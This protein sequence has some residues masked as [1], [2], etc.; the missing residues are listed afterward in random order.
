ML[1]PP[2]RRGHRAASPCS[3][4]A[5]GRVKADPGQI[6][7]VIMNLAVNARDA[8]PRRRPADDRDRRRRPRRRVRRGHPGAAPGRT[9][10]GRDRHRHRHGR[11]D[12]GPHLR[13]VLH[14]QGAGQGHRPGLST[15]YGIVEAERRLR[16]ASTASRAGHDVSTSTCRASSAPAAAAASR[17]A[18]AGAPG[19]RH[20][21]ILLVEDEAAVRELAR[22]DPRDDGLH[23]AARPRDGAEALASAATRHAARST[24]CSPTSSCR[25]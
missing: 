17:R 1:R 19:A 18:S 10:P 20:E 22:G 15:V 23:R 5:L 12:A 13:A 8:M 14:D 3:T 6:E 21:T 11:R 9:S 25:R 4:P 2:D 16:S 7:Q 24:C